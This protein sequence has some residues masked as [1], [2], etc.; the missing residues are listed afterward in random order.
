[1]FTEEAIRCSFKTFS[2]ISYSESG[3]T[4]FLRDDKNI[5][6]REKIRGII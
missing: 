4:I 6:G 1:M 5:E 2:K 3:I